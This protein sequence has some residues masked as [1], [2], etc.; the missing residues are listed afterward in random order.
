[1]IRLLVFVVLVLVPP[2]FAEASDYA[3]T[4]LQPD[5]LAVLAR[6]ERKASTQ[7]VGK[8]IAA[9]FGPISEL[10]VEYAGG[11]NRSAIDGDPRKVQQRIRERI[12]WTNCLGRDS[13]VG[14][15]KAPWIRGHILFKNGRVLPVEILLSGIVV[16]NLLFGYE[17]EPTAPANGASPHR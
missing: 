16:G 1:M 5:A 4:I 15:H 17:P 2:A 10:R 11:A 14:W 6:E 13:E 12:D 8:T 7:L 9:I 3:V